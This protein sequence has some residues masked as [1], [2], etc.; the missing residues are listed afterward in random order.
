LGHQTADEVRE[1]FL[2]RAAIRPAGNNRWDARR[3]ETYQEVA[4]DEWN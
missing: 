3:D 4:D 2:A 1:H